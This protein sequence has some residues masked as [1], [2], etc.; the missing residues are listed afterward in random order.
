MTSVQAQKDYEALHEKSRYSRILSGITSIL[1]WDQETYMP[2]AASA[3]RSEQLKVL[4]GII[5]KSKTSPASAKSLAKLIDLE[6]G[7]TIAKGL[8]AQQKA[9]L[10][11]WR[12]DY[13]QEKCLSA[14]FVEE[15]TATTS[16]AIMA[17]RTAKQQNNFSI[18]AP[19]LEKIIYMNRKKA[20]LLGYQD[21]PYD[22]LLD[23]YE[24]HTST[25]EVAT[26]F[27]NLQSSLTNLLKKIKSS[28]KIDNSFLFGNFD[29]KKQLEFGHQ[30]MN[31]MGYDQ[32]KGRL[33]ISSHPFSS[34]SHPTDS[35]ITTRLHPHS[36]MSSI[37]AIMHEAGHG[38]YEMGLLP[39]HYGSPL[40]EAVSL[41]LHESQ[42]RWWETRI[43]QS[44]PFWKH[45]F[46]LLQKMFP[47]QLEKISIPSF[48]KAINKVESSLIRVE[49][50][51]VTYS[52]HI[53]LR[54]ELEKAL[55]EGSLSVDEIPE[56]WN[57]KMQELLNLTPSN[58][59]EG[60]LQDIHWSTG[61]FGYFPTYTLGNLYAS[62]LFSAFEKQHPDWQEQVSRGDLL[63]IKEWLN[64]HVH[65]YGRQYDSK[66][67]LKLVTKKEFNE[68][69]YID[70]LYNKYKSIYN[71]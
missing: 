54:F 13:Q 12:R 53:I 11:V 1:D 19:Y 64:L 67:L 28:K 14:N 39:E 57:A 38:L 58:P 29:P 49:A 27:A 61:S 25:A 3:I 36:L 26:I 24:P 2:Y 20:D 70:Y 63:F 51:E 69:A 52:L 32:S 17:W 48:Y 21:H 23:L 65:R 33:D 10:Q 47:Q 56:A 30:L 34:A 35:R 45:F 5:H 7:K 16:Q 9:A 43:G 60:C 71:F 44:K 66:K 68:E 59:A 4:A 8:S 15:F 31:A 41:G 42:S 22:A 50:D 40:G 6:T 18:L 46:P 55:I 62:H 37:S